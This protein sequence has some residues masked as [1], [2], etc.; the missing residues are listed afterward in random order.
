MSNKKGEN[1]NKYSISAMC[2]KLNISRSLI[3][4]KKVQI[5][6][7]SDL[8]NMIIEIFKSSNRAYGTRKIK[9]E[10]KRNKL[11]VSR[12]RISRIM[13]KY[14]LTSTYTQKKY[15]KPPSDVNNEKVDNIVNRNFDRDQLLE[16]VVSD[17]AYVQVGKK[18]NY[19]CTILDL[20]NR[21]IIGYSCGENKDAKLVLREFSTIKHPLHK[22]MIFHTDRGS[23]FK[24]IAIDDLLK[25]FNIDRSLSRKGL[26]Y[27]NAVAEATFKVIK[28]EFV[29]Q[30]KFETLWDL[31]VKLM[32][33]INWY[34]N[35]RFHGSLDYMTPVEY[36]KFMSEKKVS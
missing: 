27:D 21:E 28:T 3:Y 2:K 16:V 34:N 6:M 4:Y 5:V 24:N 23:E 31:R 32:D 11:H 15:K 18:W 12:R 35:V 36:R 29:Y 7:D 30:H 22:I 20:H 9:E 10:L 17:L 13:K 19:I 33:Y 8:E 26:P 14:A 1:P 25:T